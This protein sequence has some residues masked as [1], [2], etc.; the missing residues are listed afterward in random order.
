MPSLKAR[1]CQL[2]HLNL[3]SLSSEDVD[4]QPHFT[5]EEPEAWAD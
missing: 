2:S 1:P 4:R 5:D 3:K